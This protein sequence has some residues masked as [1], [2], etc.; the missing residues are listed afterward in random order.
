MKKTR[1]LAEV[2]AM[3]LWVA[4]VLGAQTPAAAPAFEVAA[5][6]PAPPLDPAKIMAGK[7]HVGMTINAGRVDI[8]LTSSTLRTVL[9]IFSSTNASAI[10][11]ARPPKNPSKRL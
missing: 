4:G 6:K 10:P 9:S 5:I 3:F 8:T 11:A 2:G 1:V 7:L